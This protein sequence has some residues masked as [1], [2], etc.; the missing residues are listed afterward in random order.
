MSDARTPVAD[1]PRTKSGL[2]P[3]SLVHIG[4]RKIDE[5]KITVIE[6]DDGFYSKREYQSLGDFSINPDRV[7]WVNVD[8]VHEAK[9]IEDIG[10]CFGLHALVLE[11]VM[12]TTQRPKL[13]EYDECLFVVL[14]MLDVD[15]GEHI[16]IEQISVVIGK[17]FVLTFGERHGDVFDPVRDRIKRSLGKIRKLNA[18]YLAYRLIDAVVDNYFVVLDKMGDLLENVEEDIMVDPTKVDARALHT[19]KREMLFLRKA[20]H[21][22]RELLG[23]LSRVE[24]SD[25]L[26]ASTMVYWRDVYD[27]SVQVA[28]TLESQREILASM[29]DVYHSALSNRMNEVMK[30]LAIVS[31][32]F[33]PL[34][35]IVG[36]YG[37]N[38]D[39]MPELRNP[40]GYPSVLALMALVAVAMVYWFRRKRWF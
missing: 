34:T 27:H 20:I 6:Y 11:D 39:V 35:F 12:N 2:P 15:K 29:L 17:S 32:I 38:F 14:K 28:E 4:E 21:P 25:V 7:T 31:S 23:T 18:D 13:E 5:S 24:E 9:N 19:L 8:G 22:A 26:R 37:M 36:I 30:T 16:M 40:W 33:I 10:R 1:P 3:G